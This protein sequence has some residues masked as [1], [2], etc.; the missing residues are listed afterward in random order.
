MVQSL[1]G[2]IRITKSIRFF[3]KKPE[4]TRRDIRLYETLAINEDRFQGKKVVEIYEGTKQNPYNS[5]QYSKNGA[6][7]RKF[8]RNWGR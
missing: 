4:K 3:D 1:T 2:T 7:M 8:V 6:A 5:G